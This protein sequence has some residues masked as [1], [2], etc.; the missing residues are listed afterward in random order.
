MI[1]LYVLSVIAL[2]SAQEATQFVK[3]GNDAKAQK[4]QDSIEA[5]MRQVGEMGM[6]LESYRRVILGGIT[7]AADICSFIDRL[8][9]NDHVDN[10]SDGN[11]IGCGKYWI[12]NWFLLVTTERSTNDAM[13][14]KLYKSFFQKLDDEILKSQLFSALENH[15]DK[16]FS[17]ASA[18]Q[19][20][21]KRD[22]SQMQKVRFHSWG[23]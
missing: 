19:I 3:A 2:C 20:L 17:A 9:D 8:S 14:I 7:E 5:L 23:D 22:K 4:Q 6:L 11:L 21:A 1:L 13:G 16:C 18:N 10:I 15:I 12:E